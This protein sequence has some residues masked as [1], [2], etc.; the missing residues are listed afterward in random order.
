VISSPL[1]DQHHPIFTTKDLQD[2]WFNCHID[3][4]FSNPRKLNPKSTQYPDSVLQSIYKIQITTTMSLSFL[5]ELAVAESVL[6]HYLEPL[7]E[8]D[9]AF[10]DFN[11]TANRFV[12]GDPGKGGLVNFEIVTFTEEHDI[13]RVY[14]GDGKASIMC[15]FWWTLS[16]PGNIYPASPLLS[17]DDYLSELFAVC[18]E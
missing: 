15:G 11:S 6:P 1:S 2:L 9:P 16:P 13:Y 5:R 12:L 14:G 3:T 8:T 10:E 4:T 18:P 7:P 17:A